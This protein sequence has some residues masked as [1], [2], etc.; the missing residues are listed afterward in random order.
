[1]TFFPIKRVDRES[2]IATEYLGSKPKF[3][4]RDGDRQLL[5]KAEVR[6]TGE[7][8]AEVVASELCDRLGLPHVQYS[9]ASE[10]SEGAYQNPGTVCENLAPSPLVLFLGN[11]LLLAE[12][13]AYPKQQR[14]K[15]QQHCRLAVSDAIWVFAPP[16]GYQSMPKR[17]QSAGGAFIGYLMLDAWIANTDRHHENWGVVWDGQTGCLAPTFDHGAAFG[18]SLLDVERSE[19]LR[20]RDRNRTVESFARRGSSALY[21]SSDTAKPMGL[22]EAFKAFGELEARAADAWL[23]ILAGIDVDNVSEI[24]DRI[25][26]DRIS[27]VGREFTQQLL[28]TNQRRL[29]EK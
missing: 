3:W 8:W 9:L 21:L 22:L 19:R 12:D 29:L 28:K 6:G 14:F 7:D 18:H 24:L 23:E 16:A 26:D 11:D 4:F 15:V 1:M 27:T 5:F 10:F 20:T 13:A 25:P 17:C 2:A